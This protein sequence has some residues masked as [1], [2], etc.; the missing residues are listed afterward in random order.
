MLY[1][2]FII[3][4]SDFNPRSPRGGATWVAGNPDYALDIS[5]HAPHEGERRAGHGGARRGEKVFQST[6]PARGSDTA[7]SKSCASARDFNP[8]SPQGGAT[9][10]AQRYLGHANAFQSTLPARGSDPLPCGKPVSLCGYFNPRSPQG[11]ATEAQGYIVHHKQISIHAPRKGERRAVAAR[12]AGP[13]TISIHAPR[14]GERRDYFVKKLGLRLISIHAPRKG[15]RPKFY[16]CKPSQI[17]FQSTLPARGSDT[18]IVAFERD[19]LHFNPR[20]P[21]GGATRAILCHIFP[22]STFQSTL[23][24]RGSDKHGLNPS[25]VIIDISIHAPR[26]GERQARMP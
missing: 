19:K 2:V 16:R 8:R 25:V 6:L 11:G 3:Y 10:S 20:S 17:I 14:K 7:R 5:I 15:E 9:L 24:A 23:P 12:T 18:K 13:S 4:Y 22:I 26:K 1:R 21:Q